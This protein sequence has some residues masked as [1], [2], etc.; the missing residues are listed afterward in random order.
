MPERTVYISGEM[1]PESEA[2]IS[3]FD[4][5]VM[6]GDTVTESTRTFNHEP[7]RLHDHLVRLYKSLKITRID[8]GMS[9][10]EMEQVTLD[11]MRANLPLYAPEMDLW[12]V[13]NISRG[14]YPP[15]G[16]QSAKRQATIIIHT[17]PMDLTY[18]AE[19]YVRGCHAVTPPSRVTPFA[20]LDA[21]IKNRSRMPYTLAEL[22][23][24]LVDPR[25]QGILLDTDGYLAE[26]KG[27]NFFVVADGTLKTP[28]AINALAGIT[29]D[30]T[31]QLARD[32]GIPTLECDLQPYDIYTADE[33]F[34]TSTPYC[35]MPATKFNGLPVGDG[36]VGPI[37]R[38]LLDAWSGLAG[39][40]IVERA[41][42][43]LDADLCNELTDERS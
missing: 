33:A 32:L 10:E 22:E 24:K 41:L 30:M 15:S 40:D 42:A 38:R 4:S 29:R 43:Q 2:K 8:A 25:A 23:V 11:V 3:I 13:H 9:I 18:W 21:K 17:Q 27:G 6:L 19:F 7:F 31:L 5:A 35:I 20:S 16:D 12:I 39:F 28:R 34:F 14:A 1:V 26:N 37:T 36:K